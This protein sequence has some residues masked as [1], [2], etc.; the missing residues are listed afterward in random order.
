M[1]GKLFG[2]KNKS[3]SEPND[4]KASD[5]SPNMIGDDDPR[6]AEGYVRMKAAWDEVGPSDA[7]VITYMINPQFQG[8][9]AWP[10]T[11][12]AYRV[13]RPPGSLI[14]ASDGLSDPFVG[15][16]MADTQGFGCEVYIEAPEFA[17]A[18]FQG[19]RDSWAFS[20]IENFAMNVANWGGISRQLEQ[21][22]VL[23]MELPAQGQL[24][25]AW[26]TP[27]GNAGFLI[28]VPGVGRPKR[29]DMPF[30]PVDLIALTLLTPDE[31][32]R[33]VAGGANGRKEVAAELAAKGV[34]HIS[35]VDRL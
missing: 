19:L 16:D 11:R 20:L 5:V 15:T 10:N 24:P 12:Q 6:I 33:I 35:R 23:S 34:G 17:G 2:G 22:G 28:G 9:P 14:I 31:L 25:D 29:I 8:K 30:G 26:L 7:D 32:A 21:N 3:G 18:D 13:V 27:E 4:P 1:F